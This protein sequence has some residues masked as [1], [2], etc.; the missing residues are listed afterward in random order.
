MYNIAHRGYSGRYPENTMLAFQ[1]AWEAGCDGIEL[2]VQLTKDDIIVIMHDERIDRTSDGEGF[3]RDYTYEELFS[4]DCSFK[5]KGQY[6]INKIPTLEEYLAWVKPTGLFT[7]IELKNSVYYYTKL[8]DKVIAMVKRFEM[9]EKVMFS[10]F[11]N[12]SVLKC[13]KLMPGIKMGFLTETP[14]GNAGFYTSEYGIEAYHPDLS[15]LTKEEVDDCKKHN[16]A[17]NV[18]T[19][20]KEEDMKKMLDWGVDGVF[21]NEP[22]VLRNLLDQ[23]K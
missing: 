4:F 13:K 8:E 10:S 5:F 6:G 3:I 1:K 14:I 7:N 22:E 15:W 12:V 16:V 17:V 18:W 2:D 20:N 23:I 9:E 21:T 19:V 11:S